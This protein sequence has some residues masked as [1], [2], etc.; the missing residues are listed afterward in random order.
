MTPEKFST[1]LTKKSAELK[2]FLQTKLPRYVGKLA[3]DFFQDNFRRGGW[4]YGGLKRWQPP[5]RFN[6]KGNVGCELLYSASLR[7]IASLSSFCI[8]EI[9]NAARLK[10][11]IIK[12][13]NTREGFNKFYS[14]IRVNRYKLNRKI[15]K[16]FNNLPFPA[17]IREIIY[18]FNFNIRKTFNDA[19]PKIWVNIYNLY[20]TIQ[21]YALAFAI[22]TDRFIIGKGKTHENNRYNNYCSHKIFYENI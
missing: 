1:L 22:L 15:W 13:I 19:Y 5:K 10:L 17:F 18:H 2:T 20:L 7:E 9:L 3:V 11:K 21:G 16:G 4:Q 8:F 12:L 14:K 6:E